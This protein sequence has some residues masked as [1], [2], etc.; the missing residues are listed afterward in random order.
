[1]SMIRLPDYED[2]D[3]WHLADCFVIDL[4]LHP[5]TLGF[6]VL[7]IPYNCQIEIRRCTR[8]A[9]IPC[10]GLVV[11][12]STHRQFS[13][14]SLCPRFPKKRLSKSWTVSSLFRAIRVVTDPFVSGLLEAREEV[15]YWADTADRFRLQ[16]KV[17]LRVANNPTRSHTYSEM[18]LED[19]AFWIRE[20]KILIDEQKNAKAYQFRSVKIAPSPLWPDHKH[21]ART[22]RY[23]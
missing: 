16:D 14:M 8:K 19:C 22:S 13:H 6:G 17:Q 11:T 12:V 3:L 1:M 2:L 5:V 20:L 10:G 23:D 9:S 21:Y 15:K 7:W 4:G 18:S